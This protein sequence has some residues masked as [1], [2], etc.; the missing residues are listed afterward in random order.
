MKVGSIIKGKV[1]KFNTEKI[2]LNFKNGYKGVVEKNEISDFN[3]K[4]ISSFLAVNNVIDVQILEKD[5]KN[6]FLKC[7]FKSLRANFRKKIFSYTLEPTKNGFTNLLNLTN[8][9]L[10]KWEE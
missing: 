3:T 5:I 10:K 7:S 4:N 6:K 8:K 1:E 2:Y 9:E